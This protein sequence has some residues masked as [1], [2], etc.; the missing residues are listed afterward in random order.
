MSEKS[1]KNFPE[2]IT[3]IQLLKNPAHVTAIEQNDFNLEKNWDTTFKNND[4]GE[5][6]KGNWTLNSTDTSTWATI[7]VPFTA[8]KDIGSV[9]YK[10][11][12]VVTSASTASNP[13]SIQLGILVEADSTYVNGKLVGQTNSEWISRKYTIPANTLVVGRNTITVRLV[14]NSLKGGF[15]GSVFELVGAGETIDLKGTWKYKVGYAA[16]ALPT[17]VNLRWKPTALYNAMIEPLKNY[18]LKGAIWYQGEGNTSKPTQYTIYLRSMIEDWR[19]LFKNPSMPF[20]YVQLPNYQVSKA[21][22]SESNWALLRESQLK[23]LAVPHTGMA[24]TIDVG[25]WYNLHPISKK[26]VG[27]R[28]ALAAQR[29]AYN[30]QMVVSSG[31]MYQSMKI[32]G[33][34]I[35]LS[36]TSLGSQLKFISKATPTT[37]THSNFAIAG[38]NKV[39]AWAQARIEGNKV[40]V[41][42]DAILNPVAVRYAWSDNPTGTK[43]FNSETLPLPASPFRT[44]SLIIGKPYFLINFN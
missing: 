14:N 34:T 41:W 42:N 38:S 35:E 19:L 40:I 33:N 5:V 23:T 43:L 26:P 30:E 6:T 24:T 25:E 29:V 3:E 11:D 2:T 36:F 20:V 17:P 9:W 37:T 12:I 4:A 22:P 1:L 18:A 28:L 44:D 39:F 16:T 8:K 10:K 7:T 27:I 31:P 15:T 32:V 21:D 13:S